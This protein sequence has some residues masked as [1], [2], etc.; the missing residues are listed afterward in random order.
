MS[1]P[2]LSQSGVRSWSTGLS[3]VTLFVV[4]FDAQ[5]VSAQTFHGRIRHFRGMPRFPD[6][7][8]FM[9][10]D[11]SCASEKAHESLMYAESLGVRTGVPPTTTHV[12]PSR[13]HPLRS[14]ARLRRILSS[15][16]TPELHRVS[17]RLPSRFPKERHLELLC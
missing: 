11:S 6:A 14:R 7:S 13:P 16:P 5:G 12:K 15:C 17:A 8:S 9:K 1:R 4:R 3:L 10:P 2:N